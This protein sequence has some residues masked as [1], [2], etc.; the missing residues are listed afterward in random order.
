MRCFFSSEGC[1]EFRR[2]ISRLSRLRGAGR[3]VIEE[4]RA[5]WAA[6]G[7]HHVDEVMLAAGRAED[8]MVV[9]RRQLASEIAGSPAA[10]SGSSLSSRRSPVHATRC[11]TRHRKADWRAH[12][13][14]A[15]VPST[16]RP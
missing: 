10:G 1:G 8:P 13:C 12:G 2:D 6:G 15:V 11:R 7:A 14:G 5:R 3:Q 4:R 9:S 16:A